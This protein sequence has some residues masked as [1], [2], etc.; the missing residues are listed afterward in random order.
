MA[1]APK[2]SVGITSPVSGPLQCPMAEMAHCAMS[3]GPHSNIWTFARSGDVERETRDLR[4]FKL[5]DLSW[6]ETGA[7]HPVTEAL[8]ISFV[9]LRSRLQSHRNKIFPLNQMWK[10]SLK[11]KQKLAVCSLLFLKNYAMTQN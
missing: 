11:L 5:F 7:Y 2:C 10:F 9:K 8:L 3:D 6:A 1:A 4:S